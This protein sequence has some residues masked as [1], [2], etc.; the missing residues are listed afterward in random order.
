MDNVC[1]PSVWQLVPTQPHRLLSPLT[2]FGQNVGSEKILLAWAAR[3]QR[4][5]LSI[6]MLGRESQTGYFLMFEDESKG[7]KN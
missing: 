7:L 1:R 3:G 6:F 5:R 2:Y 4:E